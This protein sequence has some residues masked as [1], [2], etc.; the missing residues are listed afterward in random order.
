MLANSIVGEMSSS[1][2]QSYS[3]AARDFLASDAFAKFHQDYFVTELIG[4]LEAECA[5]GT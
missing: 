4:I 2:A 3:N 5:S 1:E